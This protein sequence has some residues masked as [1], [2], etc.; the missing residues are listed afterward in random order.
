MP[1]IQGQNGRDEVDSVGRENRDDHLVVDG[2]SDV[3]SCFDGAE[4]GG[5]TRSF[6]KRK[7]EESQGKNERSRRRLGF[8]LPTIMYMVSVENPKM[9]IMYFHFELRRGKR[10]KEL[11]K[12]REGEVER[13]SDKT[14]PLGLFPIENKKH[15]TRSPM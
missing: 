7:R 10:R 14:H 15:A 6:S 5:C 3:R 4:D 8:N 12:R 13:S 1:R 11:E 9:A 2:V